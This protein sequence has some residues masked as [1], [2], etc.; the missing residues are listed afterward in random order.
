MSIEIDS[1][2]LGKLVVNP[3]LLITF[4]EGIPGF[5]EIKE[6]ALIPPGN[7]SPF[8]WLQAF[9]DPELAFVVTDPLFFKADYHPSYPEEEIKLLQ[10]NDPKSLITLVLV[11]IPQGEPRRSTANLMA[12][13]CINPETRTGKQVI[14]YH[15]SYSHQVP[16]FLQKT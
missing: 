1:V 9:K 8:Y 15:S 12:P 2:K 6:Y 16:L 7:D 5:Q 4:P 11:T 13:I 10:V 14:L 3:D